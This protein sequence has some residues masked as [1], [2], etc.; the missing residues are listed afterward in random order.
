MKRFWLFDTHLGSIKYCPS[1]TLKISCLYDPDGSLY[2]HKE[3]YPEGQLRMNDDHHPQNRKIQEFY[4][5]GDLKSQTDLYKSLMI[6]KN[7]YYPGMKL[8]SEEIYKLKYDGI[9]NNLISV[10]GKGSPSRSF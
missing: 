6:K 7:E 3:Y 10:V 1:G 4:E 2:N 9:F 8:F 5:N